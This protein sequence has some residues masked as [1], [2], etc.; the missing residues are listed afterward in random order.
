M[1]TALPLAVIA[2]GMLSIAG[3]AEGGNG[4]D[5]VNGNVDV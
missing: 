4:L 5:K 2:L 3:C 1:R